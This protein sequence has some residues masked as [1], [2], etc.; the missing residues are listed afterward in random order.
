MP[1]AL[2]D[3]ARRAY[4]QVVN[5][6]LCAHTAAPTYKILAYMHQLN[7]VSERAK[8]G[9]EFIHIACQQKQRNAQ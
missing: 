9:G 6:L 8:L 4:T 7:A 3:G 2:T 5:P 1:N